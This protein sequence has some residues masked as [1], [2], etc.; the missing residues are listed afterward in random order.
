VQEQNNRGG[1]EKLRSRTRR[2]DRAEDIKLL[3][4]IVRVA[5]IGIVWCLGLHWVGTRLD[6]NETITTSEADSH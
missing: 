3:M 5:L 6:Y 2:E 1:E 4:C